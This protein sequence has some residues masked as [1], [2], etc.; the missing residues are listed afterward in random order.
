MRT[1]A[2]YRATMDECDELNQVGFCCI[3]MSQN[4]NDENAPWS[5]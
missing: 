4:G 2:L 5:A 3:F 1:F